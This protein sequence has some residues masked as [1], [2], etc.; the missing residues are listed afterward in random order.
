QFRETGVQGDGVIHPDTRR[1]SDDTWDYYFGAGTGEDAAR[2][3]LQ[4]KTEQFHTSYSGELRGRALAQAEAESETANSALRRTAIFRPLS[5]WELTEEA[6]TL[7]FEY[8]PLEAVHTNVN[9]TV[10]VGGST[11]NNVNPSE[12][13]AALDD[14]GLVIEVPISASQAGNV[15]QS[16]NAMAGYVR[17]QIQAGSAD[18]VTGWMRTEEPGAAADAEAGTSRGQKIATFTLPT[19][20]ATGDIDGATGTLEAGV[21]AG[22]S[23]GGT[24]GTGSWRLT[25]PALPPDDSVIGFWAVAKEGAT[26]TSAAFLPW[27]PGAA[28]GD[29]ATND[30]GIG[31][32]HFDDTEKVDVTYL[33]G[34]ETGWVGSFLLFRGDGDVL[35]ANA[36]VEFYQAIVSGP[37]GAKGDKGDTGNVPG[38]RPLTGSSPYTVLTTDQDFLVEVKYTD[39]S[40]SAYF[41]KI[42]PR[43]LL[44]TTAKPFMVDA[45]NPE[46]L[47]KWFGVNAHLNAA[48]TQ[49]VISKA[50]GGLNEGNLAKW[51]FES[52]H[53]R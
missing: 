18:P 9:A 37:A 28:Q 14:I 23:L 7:R 32:V 49:L 5:V 35:P 41:S 34:N 3:V 44:T 46:T 38:W 6:R 47:N 26:E 10:N 33:Q 15:T 39:N 50:T 2:V 8:R 16:S 51:T 40:Q 29:S 24:G 42:I 22:Y 25:V 1:F 36:T 31:S 20:A 21:P 48:G 45:N 17:V 27:G 30:L 12:G 52:T 11:I 13:I 19:A 53:A 4:R 43:V